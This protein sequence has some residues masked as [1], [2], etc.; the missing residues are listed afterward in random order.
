MNLPTS[1][2]IVASR[3][4]EMA[5]REFHEHGCNDVDPEVF[6]GV[7]VRQ[8]K[9]LL[10]DFNEWYQST[11]LVPMPWVE[12]QEVRDDQWMEFFAWKLSGKPLTPQF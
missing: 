7:S 9:I 2:A 12:F 3:L 6:K 11:F 10:E 5:A 1:H 4:L 8:R